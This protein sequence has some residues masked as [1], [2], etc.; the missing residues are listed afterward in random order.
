GGRGPPGAGG[1]GFG[2]AGDKRPGRPAR[3][4]RGGPPP[5]TAPRVEPRLRYATPPR[6]A[7]RCSSTSGRGGCVFRLGHVRGRSAPR[8][9]E[10]S[11]RRFKGAG[12]R[13]NTSDDGRVAAIS[14]GVH[15]TEHTTD[16]PAP[17]RQL[18]NGCRYAR[19]R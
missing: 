1:A 11:I 13:P 6:G 5:P 3:R 2:P 7:K 15:Q 12:A 4:R 9:R 16:P 14:G 19:G 10:P 8:E 18:S 17:C